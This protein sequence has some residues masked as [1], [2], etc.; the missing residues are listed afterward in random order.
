MPVR[1]GLRAVS[2]TST[3]TCPVTTSTSGQSVIRAALTARGPP[4]S[5]GS[6]PSSRIVRTNRCT[7]ADTGSRPVSTASASQASFA[8]PAAQCPIQVGEQLRPASR[9]RPPERGQDRLDPSGERLVAPVG[10]LLEELREV[11]GPISSDRSPL[12]RAAPRASPS[13]R[14]GPGHRS[15]AAVGHASRAGARRDRHP[16]SRCPD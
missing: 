11:Y 9:N 3:S 13:R 8:P 7:S 4:T 2:C 14:A 10:A 12:D 6:G 5:A 16:G 1:I 15:P